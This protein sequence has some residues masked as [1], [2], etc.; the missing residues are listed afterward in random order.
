VSKE[1]A[2][3]A[4]LGAGALVA[5]QAPVNSVLSRSVGTFGAASVNF[6]VG[7]VLLLLVTFVLAGGLAGSGDP[8]PWYAYVIGGLAGAAYVTTALVAVRHVGAG[9]VTAATIAGQFA[10]SLVL[11]R[12]G[13]FGLEERALSPSRVLGV[14]LLAVGTWLMVRD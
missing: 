11:D 13:A 8:A 2:L 9:G 3:G 6:L 5:V 4:T 7:T 14:A 12:V 1:V 10:A